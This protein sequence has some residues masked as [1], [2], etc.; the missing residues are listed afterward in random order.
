MIYTYT[1]L[2]NLNGALRMDG[3][4]RDGLSF[5]QTACGLLGGGGRPPPKVIERERRALPGTAQQETFF[6][7]SWPL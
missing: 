2:L 4:C 7:E 3:S 6:V 5:A 1:R